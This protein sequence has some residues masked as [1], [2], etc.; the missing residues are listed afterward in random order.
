MRNLRNSS[1]QGLVEF[2]LVFPI[3]VIML[4]GLFDVGRAVFAYNEI[5][6]SAREGTRLG[7]VNQDV[8]TIQGRIASQ[9][10]AV[11][12]SSC[13]SFFDAGTSFATC[14]KGTAVPT[15]PC[16]PQPTVGCIAHVE[17][18]TDFS[19]ITP[20]IGTLIGN[21]TLTANSEAS[22]EFVCPNVGIAEW[23]SAAS[24]PKQP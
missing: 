10:T 12:V 14:N 3:F 2:A 7:I 9:S 8:A 20:I 11:A 5:T 4:F 22:V 13:V 24:C 19:P 17:V 1:G 16:P 21:F 15:S 18:W 23:N 6:N